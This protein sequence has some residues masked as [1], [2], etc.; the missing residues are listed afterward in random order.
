[1][2][3]RDELRLKEFPAPPVIG[4]RGQ[5]IDERDRAAVLAISALKPPN[6][7]D[8]LFFNAIFCFDL[9]QDAGMFAQGRLAV[10]DPHGRGGAVE[11]IPDL[12]REFRLVAVL[13]D[14][15]GVVAHAAKGAFEHVRADALGTGAR[16]E[17]VD[18]ALETR[19]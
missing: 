4:Q 3:R 9:V 6:L 16:F 1:M 15:V 12:F 19:V 17:P 8:D 7:R 18:P 11:V 2:Q 10:L 13:L 14:H 5:G